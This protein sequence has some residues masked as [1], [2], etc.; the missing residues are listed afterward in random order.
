MQ[1]IA[2]KHRHQALVV[3]KS[4]HIR[5]T[6]GYLRECLFN[7]CQGIIVDADFLDLFAG[8]GAMGLEALS[9]GA[10]HAIFVDNHPFSIKSIKENIKKLKEE[11]HAQVIFSDTFDALKK[12][13]LKE[14]QFDIVYADPPYQQKGSIS[15]SNQ[16]LQ[17]FDEHPQMLKS[18]GVLF[19]EDAE[20]HDEKTIELKHFALKSSRKMGIS[21]LRQYI[22]LL[23]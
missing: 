22:R 6:T 19:L 23:A 1:I 8:C 16:V 2:G 18:Y 13:A 11:E 9:R 4:H 15:L 14:S 7:I 5:P 10:N 21:T 17:W 3:P 12:L 20:Q